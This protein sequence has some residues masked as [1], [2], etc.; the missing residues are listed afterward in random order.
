MRNRFCEFRALLAQSGL[1]SS[2]MHFLKYAGVVSS[3][4][5]CSCT[6]LLT[7]PER[8]T[9]KDITDGLSYANAYA[10]LARARD[11]M[12]KDVT[13]LEKLDA[14][15][16]GM[17]A[18]GV[19]GAGMAALFKGSNDLVLSLLTVGGAGYVT[20]QNVQPSVRIGI[21][22]AGLKNLDCID[23]AALGLNLRN[24]GLK[25][26]RHRLM[27][28]IGRL[29]D[30]IRAG[31]R[32]TVQGGALTEVIDKAE[33]AYKTAELLVVQIDGAVSIDDKNIGRTVYSAVNQTVMSVSQQLDS[34]SPNIDAIA[35]SSSIS[36]FVSSH[37]A[38]KSD[39]KATAST[40]QEALSK[41][42]RTTQL[43]VAPWFDE[44]KVSLEQ[45]TTEVAT[46]QKLLSSD[47]IST[48]AIGTCKTITP[49][50]EPMRI[51]LRDDVP[52]TGVPL[53][54]GESYN[55]EVIGDGAG[56]PRIGWSGPEPTIAQL[57]ATLSDGKLQVMAPPNA[58][59]GHFKLYLYDSSSK[60]STHRA[61]NQVDIII[62]SPSDK[63]PVAVGPKKDLTK[64]SAGKKGNSA[65]PS[66][67]S[68][69]GTG[70]V[71]NAGAEKLTELGLPPDV[72]PNDPRYIDR[73]KK[74]ENCAGRVPTGRMSDSLHAYIATH[75][76]IN[77]SGDCSPTTASPSGAGG[78]PPK[79]PPVTAAATPAH[80]AITKPTK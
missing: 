15:N 34:S 4:C 66:P 11:Q 57:V 29:A 3:V 73:V 79:P 17:V 80:S 48:A 52:P 27:L 13:A 40:A 10:Y 26:A 33:T 19:G 32:A 74:L 47:V 70:L 44:L 2:P 41:A 68:D 25:A 31:R 77:A 22:R 5:L 28:K 14:T 6:V 43:G 61:S 76:P 67:P 7:P 72:T 9:D 36:A 69:V 49:G 53:L 78:T 51:V 64:N 71:S 16:K 62:G 46:V 75:G 65:A 37:Q 18:G 59:P 1:D 42:Q 60:E 55:F 63:K 39:T 58:K 50:T 12:Q 21:Y 38:A 8:P 35:Q 23:D 54:A 56:T 20:N 45:L 24:E 30:A